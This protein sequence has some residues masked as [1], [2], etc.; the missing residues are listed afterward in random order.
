MRGLCLRADTLGTCVPRQACVGRACVEVLPVCR[1]GNCLKTPIKVRIPLPD[2]GPDPVVIAR[3]TQVSTFAAQPE[4]DSAV[5]LRAVAV[6]REAVMRDA[7]EGRDGTES[8]AKLNQA[9]E[10]ARAAEQK[11]GGAFVR[12][13]RPH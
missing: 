12:R 7:K 11:Q 3:P 1:N 2:P 9:V 6:A 10:A 8:L 4:P 13:R 5:L